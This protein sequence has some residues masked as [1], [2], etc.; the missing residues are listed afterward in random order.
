MARECEMDWST[1]GH[2]DAISNLPVPFSGAGS[3]PQRISPADDSVPFTLPR[4]RG[5]PS[6]A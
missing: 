6:I 3:P 2:T 1:I 5:G 4:C